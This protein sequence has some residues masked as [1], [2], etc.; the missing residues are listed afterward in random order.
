M[1]K[2][3][4]KRS[5]CGVNVGKGERG[6]KCSEMMNAERSSV[7]S[8]SVDGRFSSGVR[9]ARNPS[10]SSQELYFQHSICIYCCG[11]VSSSS[12][13]RTSGR[14][15]EGNDEIRAGP[16][17]RDFRMLKKPAVGNSRS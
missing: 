15:R 3:S 8:S 9:D 6:R 13:S 11:E 16:A 5:N 10:E 17:V 7:T 14:T 2:A 4:V 1:W 12:L